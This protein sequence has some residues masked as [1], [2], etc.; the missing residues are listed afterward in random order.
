MVTA[1]SSECREQFKQLKQSLSV[2]ILAYE[3]YSIIFREL[4]I[5]PSD[6]EDA[7]MAAA[8]ITTPQ[9]NN[10]KATKPT[11]KCTSNNVYEFCWYLFILARGESPEYTLDLVTSFHVLLCCMDLIFANVVAD[12]RDDLINTG[13][14]QTAAI[15]ISYK[16][17]TG[18]NVGNENEPVSIVK[19]LC[20]KQSASEVETLT[21]KAHDW[22]N[23]MQKFI[24]DGVLKGNSTNFLGI[25]SATNYDYNIK[26]LKRQ[27]EAYIQ[28]GG[29]LDEGIFLLQAPSDNP[30]DPKTHSQILKTY[31]PE[32]PLTC[33]NRL[34]GANEHM[35]SPVTNA[36]RNVNRLH[37]CLGKC[38]AEPSESLKDLFSLCGVD[39]F[40]EMD[41]LLQTMRDKFLNAFRTNSASDRFELAV[42]LYYNLLEKIIKKEKNQ[43]QNFDPKVRILRCML[44]LVMTISF[45]LIVFLSICLDF[46]K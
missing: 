29:K 4:F 21:I 24:R 6:A 5:S 1:T 17:R 26:S 14:N 46:E 36:T 8:T 25:L 45:Y 23:L 27:Y 44:D 40:A 42:K 15:L 19:E 32:T 18:K 3:K 11:N 22:R 28:R 35:I 33:R 43:K 31:V 41:E 37:A 12:K 10:K 2:S 9:K 38:S 30:T 13:L 39:P 7:A 34:P 20:Q 16:E